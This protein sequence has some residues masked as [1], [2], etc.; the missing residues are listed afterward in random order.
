MKLF[1]TMERQF[2][3]QTADIDSEEKKYRIRLREL[4]GQSDPETEKARENVITRKIEECVVLGTLD[5]AAKY[6]GQLKVLE[7][8]ISEREVEIKKIRGLWSSGN[9]SAGRQAIAKSIFDAHLEKSGIEIRKRI[10]ETVD[11]VE[12]LRSSLMQF[13]TVHGLQVS[14][15][16]IDT[17]CR[18]HAVG[19]DRALRSRM[20][21]FL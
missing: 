17:V 11:Y 16:A 19:D 7:D 14:T 18:I 9:F 4:E 12:D 10:T 21:D 6:R 15:H 5:E 13:V 8:A 20:A 2:S 1:D 3:E